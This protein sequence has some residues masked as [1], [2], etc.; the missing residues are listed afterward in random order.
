[1]ILTRCIFC[2]Q[3]EAAQ[4]SGTYQQ[5][6]CLLCLLTLSLR[7]CSLRTMIWE[8][9]SYWHKIKFIFLKSI[10]LLENLCSPWH[11]KM[12]QKTDAK[13]LTRK[14]YT[15]KW[16]EKMTRK[17]DTKWHEIMTRKNDTKN[18]T[19]KWHVKCDGCELVNQH[20]IWSK[21]EG[22]VGLVK[23]NMTNRIG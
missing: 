6:S 15:K 8:K 1:M 16:Y 14:N 2:R 7:C 21:R 18:D 17:N 4:R 20:S 10:Y 9:I 23:L 12:T 11:N 13:K 5:L 3:D 22:F 19:K